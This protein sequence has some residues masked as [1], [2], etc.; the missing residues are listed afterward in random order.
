MIFQVGRRLRSITNA[1]LTSAAQCYI[2][3]IKVTTLPHIRS[4][5]RTED[6]ILKVSEGPG[7]Q[8]P[9][10]FSRLMKMF[11]AARF[12]RPDFFVGITRLASKGSC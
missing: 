5:Y 6:F 10:A 1:F 7:L 11:F 9:T 4:P 8:A 3:E 2:D 12:C